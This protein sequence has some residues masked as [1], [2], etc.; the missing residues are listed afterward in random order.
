MPSRNSRASRCGSCRWCSE[1]VR[2]ARIDCLRRGRPT[3]NAKSE[4]FDGPFRAACLNAH[5][6]W[7][8]ENPRPLS[9]A[10]R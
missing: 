4:S 8:L 10:G 2:K 6:F 7:S 1:R 3:D 9:R 5:G